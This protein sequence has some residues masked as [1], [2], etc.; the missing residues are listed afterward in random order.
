MSMSDEGDALLDLLAEA[1]N[2]LHHLNTLQHSPS[3]APPP[4]VAAKTESPLPTPAS[5]ADSP[6]FQPDASVQYA[7]APE[8]EYREPLINNP[9]VRSILVMLPYDIQIAAS[10][11]L[12]QA[13]LTWRKAVVL[14][15][16]VLIIGL[17]TG[18]IQAPKSLIDKATSIYAGFSC[19]APTPLP[20]TPTQPMQ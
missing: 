13:N 19:P 4:A 3:V 9:I 8:P 18:Y 14:C 5:V 6:P 16:A 15:L 17:A 1:E 10:N 12:S 11:V 2:K 7:I 20:Q